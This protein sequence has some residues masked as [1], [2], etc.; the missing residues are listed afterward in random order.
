[1]HKNPT[2]FFENRL[3]S[4]LFAQF[5]LCVFFLASRSRGQT[6]PNCPVS[7]PSLLYSY[8]RRTKVLFSFSLLSPFP[9][10]PAARVT[11]YR[12]AIPMMPSPSS[13]L[14]Q[15]KIPLGRERRGGG[16]GRNW[17]ISLLFLSRFGS[18]GKKRE[19]GGGG[20]IGKICVRAEIEQGIRQN[21]NKSKC[22]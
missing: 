9:L 4:G 14:I 11:I 13:S 3:F 2:L 18:R 8:R 20:E 17:S 22:P 19:K 6:N 21:T 1:M 5:P 15:T 12:Y 7:P 16:G 10:S